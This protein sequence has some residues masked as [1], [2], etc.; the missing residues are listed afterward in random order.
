MKRFLIGGVLAVVCG[1]CPMVP[2]ITVAAS[3][4][5]LEPTE[6]T[7][8]A[9]VLAEEAAQTARELLQ[10]SG[11]QGGL[12]VHAGCGEGRLTAALGG[13]EA[14]LVHGLEEEPGR[15]ERAREHIR[16][17]GRYGSIAIGAWNGSHLPYAENLVNLLVVEQTVELCSEEIMRV[18]A[19]LGVALL[20]QDEGWTKLVK[21]WP[22]GLD[23]WT[24][25][26]HNPSNNA[27]AADAVVGPPQRVPSSIKLCR[28]PWRWP[29]VACSSKMRPTWSA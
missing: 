1:V 11:I 24:H 29:R 21:P 15:R 4:G 7:I 27:V 9:E 20:K 28:R 13:G 5:E 10:Q 22:A 19:P 25:Y 26:L 18:L 2:R 12:V 14:Y 6:V 8:A 23:E 17:Q 3:A 16:S